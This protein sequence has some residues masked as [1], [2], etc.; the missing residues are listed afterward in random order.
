MR[1]WKTPVSVLMPCTAA[2][3]SVRSG[4]AAAEYR[5]RS[6]SLNAFRSAMNSGVKTLIALATSARFVRIRLPARVLLAR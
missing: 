1:Y 5:I 3:W 6:F 4:T 2:V